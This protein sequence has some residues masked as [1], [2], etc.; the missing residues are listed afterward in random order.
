[1]K[2]YEEKIIS[3][4]IINSFSSVFP[5]GKLHVLF[6]LKKVILKEKTT[7]QISNEIGNIILT[8]K[9]DLNKNKGDNFNYYV[10][11][12]AN[13]QLELEKIAE[14]MVKA[15]FFGFCFCFGGLV[16]KY[17]SIEDW[18]NTTKLWTLTPLVRIPFTQQY[19][20]MEFGWYCHRLMTGPFEYKRKDFLEM[21]FHHL[22]TSILIYISFISGMVKV[23]RM[24]M[25]LHDPSDMLLAITKS[26]HY[27]K[28][29]IWP[30]VLFILFALSWFLTRI[31]LFPLIPVW[32]TF[33]EFSGPFSWC[34][35][36]ILCRI[37]L[38]FL[39]G[40][41]VYWFYLTMKVLKNRIIDSLL[42]DVRSAG[43]STEE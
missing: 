10:T 40:L 16:L 38:I 12:D 30:D 25:F 7:R 17:E 31:I 13:Y 2:T 35:S 21:N 1:M 22:I 34:Y 29:N 20:L 24:I 11:L 41:N 19:Y 3:K 18:M 27:L 9:L 6:N 32:S 8:R 42:N 26:L 5:S 4:R 33:F 37:L 23:G 43:E 28:I 14:Q 39:W 36:F 15:V